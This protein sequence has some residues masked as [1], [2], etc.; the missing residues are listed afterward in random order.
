MGRSALSGPDT[1]WNHAG[2][3]DVSGMMKR[4]SNREFRLQA[5][6]LHKDVAGAKSQKSQHFLHSFY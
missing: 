3:Y 2:T 6:G 4:L 1:V 5:E